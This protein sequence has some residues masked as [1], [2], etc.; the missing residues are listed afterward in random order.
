MH[1]KHGLALGIIALSLSPLTPSAA[2]AAGCQ[3]QSADFP[4]SAPSLMERPLIQLEKSLLWSRPTSAAADR[5]VSSPHAAA[6]ALVRGLLVANR[7]G[8]VGYTS[9]L[10]YRV[11]DV[12]RNLRRGKSLALAG[13]RAKV[14]DQVITRLLQ[15]GLQRPSLSIN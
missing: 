5:L 10:S 6:N 14:P 4:S 2:I 7:R 12:V 15:L 9:R 11:Q 8:E 3:T 1:K 13:D